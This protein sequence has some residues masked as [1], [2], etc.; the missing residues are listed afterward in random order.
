MNNYWGGYWFLNA[1]FYASIYSFALLWTLKRI[2]IWLRCSYVKLCCVGLI[3]T[4]VL[5]LLTNHLNKTFTI[6]LIGPRVFLA[7][8]FYLLG[9]IFHQ[10][11]VKCVQG[12][13]ALALSLIFI[14]LALIGMDGMSYVRYNSTVLLVPYIVGGLIGTWILYSVVGLLHR[15]RIKTFLI[16]AGNNSM[17]I[18]TWHFLMFKLISLLLVCLYALPIIHL[19]EFPVIVECSKKGWWIVYVG[20]GVSIPLLLLYFKNKVV[21]KWKIKENH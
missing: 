15:G 5:L 1:L 19:S 21:I 18:L 20:V 16:Y 17:T 8:M 3:M 4:L 2:S 12:I 13:K 7:S 14:L 9:H 11:K 6:F 10:M